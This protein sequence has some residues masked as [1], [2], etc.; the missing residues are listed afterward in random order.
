MNE[1][2]IEAKKAYDLLEVPIGCVIVYDNEIIARGHNLVESNKSSLFH[3]EIV[4]IKEANLYLG[5]WR[6][7]D[8]EMYVTL[9][10]C[11]M[12]AGAIVNS[13]IKKIYI[14]AMDKKRGCCGSNINLLNED[15]L[16]HKVE[17]ESGILEK[18]CSDILSEFFKDLRDK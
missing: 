4:A 7:I 5:G 13:R 3:A 18:K 10:P 17:I 2:L 11:S 8:C 16:N 15:Y 14:G 1:A 9:E 12:C 6:L